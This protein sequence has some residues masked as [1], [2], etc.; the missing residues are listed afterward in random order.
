MVAPKPRD[1]RQPEVSP[2]QVRRQVAEVLGQPAESLQAEAQLLARAHDIV[3][4]A[5]GSG[6]R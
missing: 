3:Q 2:D 6:R 4:D 1:P 5:L